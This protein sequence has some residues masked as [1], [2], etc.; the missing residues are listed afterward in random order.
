MAEL[1]DAVVLG[2]IG[3]P[4]RFESCYPQRRDTLKG[5]MILQG[6]SFA[7]PIMQNVDI[8]SYFFLYIA[9]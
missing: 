1:V 8:K 4:C 3:R 6:I 2:A 9:F 5:W 7:Y